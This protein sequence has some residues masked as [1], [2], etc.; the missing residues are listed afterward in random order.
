MADEAAHGLQPNLPIR[1]DR[2][3]L[4]AH[5]MADLDDLIRFHSDPEVVRYVPWPVRDRAATDQALRAKLDQVQLREPGQWLVLAVEQRDS[6]SVIGEVLLKWSS[7]ADRQGEVGFAFDREHHGQGYAAEA[8]SAMLRLGFEELGLHRI[9]AVCIEQ[10]EASARL[11][12]R[13]GFSQQGRL[14]DNVWFKGGWATQ[15]IF[16]LTEDEWRGNERPEPIQS[17]KDVAE[18]LDLVRCFFAAFTSGDGAQSRLDALRA[19]MMPTAIVVRTCGQSPIA[20][21]IESFIAPRQALLTDGSLTDFSEHAT[22]GHV[23]VFGDIA[24]WFGHY[25]KNGQFHGAPY[26]GAGMKSM[27]FVRTDDGWRISAAAWDDERP[28]LGPHDH[29]CLDTAAP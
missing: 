4:R 7:A 24:H 11:L 10:N 6:G 23:D 3:I 17:P 14:T 26:P 12:R 29:L 8:T 16:A 18:I 25:T 19:V 21:D 28:G 22:Q 27:Q 5:R 9:S 2:L 1:T 13:L 15:L 20:Y